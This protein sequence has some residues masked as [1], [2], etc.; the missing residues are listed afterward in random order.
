MKEESNK[1]GELYDLRRRMLSLGLTLTPEQEAML[2]AAE[3]RILR[4]EVLPSLVARIEP[5]LAPVERELVLVIRHVPGLPLAVSLSRDANLLDAVPDAVAIEPDPVVV[6][7]STGPYNT[8]R[9][10]LGPRTRLRVKFPDGTVIESSQA[11]DTFARAIIRL[12]LLRVRALDIRRFGMNIVS[13][14]KD[15]KYN[16]AEAPDGWYILTHSSTKEKVRQLREIS[17]RLN[18]PLDVEIVS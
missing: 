12:G 18:E 4:H 9:R 3:E 5:A 1:I 10:Q 7:T 15:D 11:S 16:Q 6:H 2:N 17:R 8:P 14:T 13:N